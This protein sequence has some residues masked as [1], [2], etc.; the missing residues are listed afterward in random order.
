MG[1]RKSG[2][3]KAIR[4]KVQKSVCNFT[5]KT[6]GKRN[7]PHKVKTVN[8][9][10]REILTH[11]QKMPRRRLRIQSSSDSEEEES[12]HQQSGNQQPT[13]THPSVNLSSPNPNTDP[14]TISLD[15]DDDDDDYFTPPSPDRTTC[16]PISDS[17]F[18]L[19]LS[20]KREW[21]DS[22]VQGLESSVSGFSQLDVSAKAKLCF[23]QFLFSDMNYS[24]AGVLPRNVQSMHLVDLKGPFV[25]QVHLRC[26]KILKK[27]ELSIKLITEF[28]F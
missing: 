26:I 10:K 27:L 16:Y 11:H 15:D 2:Q 7:R 14:V 28:S 23:Q 20:L 3:V 13:V 9:E 17:L 18:R 25:L 19:G 12:N 4:T 1:L 22:C 6:G 24:G 21:L 5:K 8:G